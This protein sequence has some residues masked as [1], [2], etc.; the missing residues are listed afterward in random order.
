[1]YTSA[2]ILIYATKAELAITD[3]S[4]VN[5]SN[6]LTN[7]YYTTAQTENRNL[8]PLDKNYTLGS[9]TTS[10]QYTTTIHQNLTIGSHYSNACTSVVYGKVF[11]DDVVNSETTLIIGKMNSAYETANTPLEIY[12]YTNFNKYV[13]F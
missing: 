8:K 9:S 7:D 4:V 6:R 5:L 3:T 13:Y 1:L 11:L 10:G 2:G 12:K